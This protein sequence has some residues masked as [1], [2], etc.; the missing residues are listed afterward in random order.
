MTEGW[1]P[2]IDS[3]ETSPAANSA[4]MLLILRVGVDSQATEPVTRDRK[5]FGQ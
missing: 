1:M 4:A 5:A 3:H 2:S